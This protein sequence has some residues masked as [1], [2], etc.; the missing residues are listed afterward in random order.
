MQDYIENFLTTIEEQEI[1]AAINLAEQ[2]TSGEIRV[3]IE[4]TSN[5]D[6]DKRVLEVFS[7][8]KMENT[9]LRNGVLI[10]VAI[11][12]KQ[13][14]IYGDIGINTVVSDGF[15]NNC[16]TII[17]HHFKAGNF[18]QGLVD[19]ILKAGE[20]LKKFFPWDAS[21]DNELSNTISK[22]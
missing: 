19:G 9:K 15:W 17:E 16:K 10:Y 21:N 13:F 3:H 4:N 5:G 8:L 7:T 22:G 6:I 11:A 1:V 18:K 12:D 2:D 20:E 14:G